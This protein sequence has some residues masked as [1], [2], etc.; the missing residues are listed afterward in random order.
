MQEQLYRASIA[1]GRGG[2]TQ[3]VISGIDIAM[4]DAQGRL[5]GKPV[6]ELLGG[7]ARKTLRAYYTGYAPEAL[8]AFGIRDMKMAVPYGPAHGEDGMRRN[9][10][11]IAQARDVLGEHALLALDIYMA[12]TVDYTLRM[13]DR[14]EKYDIA[15]LEE[16]VLPDDYEGYREIRRR[17]NTMVTGG[18]HEYT[19]SGFGRLIDDGCVDI[20]QPDI[21]R[22]GGPT[23]LRQIA[24]RAQRAGVQLVCHGIGAP[25]YQFLSTL[26][27]TTTPFVEYVDIYRGVTKEWIL[28]DDPRPVAGVITLDDRPGFGYELSAGDGPVATIW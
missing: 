12:W 10:E 20:V 27:E 19:L 18:E 2:L 5:A 7:A 4:W 14:V 22:A 25:T 17:V 21:Y 26:P 11:A 16:P 23:A 8:A 3:Q 13:Y 6:Y 15:W 9:E 1:S 24:A 28:T